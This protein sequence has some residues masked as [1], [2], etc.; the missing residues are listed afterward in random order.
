[1]GQVSDL[2]LCVQYT[3]GDQPSSNASRNR[4]RA[5]DYKELLSPDDFAVFAKL[6][7]PRKEISQT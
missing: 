6:W 2:S 1:L 4:V 3:V 7:D 5:K